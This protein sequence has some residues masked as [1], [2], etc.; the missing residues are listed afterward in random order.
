MSHDAV[1]TKIW[2]QSEFTMAEIFVM[3]N[4]RRLQGRSDTVNRQEAS[5]PDALTLFKDLSDIPQLHSP[6]LITY[7]V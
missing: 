2:I 3:T 5:H 7:V 1:T 6:I 4:Q